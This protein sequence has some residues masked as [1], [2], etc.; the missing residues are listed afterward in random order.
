M[1][2]QRD[3]SHKPKLVEMTSNLNGTSQDHL[4]EVTSLETRATLL[5]SLDIDK[6]VGRDL[7]VLEFNGMVASWDL[8]AAT[9]LM[10]KEEV[11]GNMPSSKYRG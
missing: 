7:P 1:E 3:K 9:C 11:L 2:S 8:N 5:M 10:P 6:A 4:K